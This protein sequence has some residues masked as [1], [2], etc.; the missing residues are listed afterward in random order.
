MRTIAIVNQKGGT[1]KSTTAHAIGAG[2]RQRGYKVLSVDLD[3]QGDL[4]FM[5]R[6]QTSGETVT[7]ILNQIIETGKCDT[8]RAIQHTEQGD[9]IASSPAL[10]GADTILADVIGKEY[11]VKELLLPLQG[12]YDYCIIDCSPA[13]GTLTVNALTASTDVIAPCQADMLSLK[14]LA[15]LNTT[16]QAVK[17][18]CNPALNF[19]GVVITRYSQRAVLGRELAEKLT[20]LAEQSGAKVFQSRIREA[21]A[22]KEAQLL[23]QDIYSYA[24]KATATQDYRDLV[25]EIIKETQSHE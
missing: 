14:A 2:L 12:L 9:L 13:L 24:P 3:G 7:A 10:T 18:Y 6:G 17:K 1:A 22:V 16:L 25:E 5:M 20:Q 23:Q 4:S 19:M 11:K 21:T 15:Q 8:Q